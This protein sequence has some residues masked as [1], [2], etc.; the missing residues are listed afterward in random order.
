[1]ILN[2]N[3]GYTDLAM[4][5]SSTLDNAISSQAPYPDR[6]FNT[7]GMFSYALYENQMVKTFVF[8]DKTAPSSSS[9]TGTATVFGYCYSTNPNA[10]V[11]IRE[12]DKCTDKY[13]NGQ[14][15]VINGC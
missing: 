8:N 14:T 7:A 13:S 12:K 10:R 2:V 11:Y 15:S 4:S 6:I 5:Q 9:Q 3:A 1:M